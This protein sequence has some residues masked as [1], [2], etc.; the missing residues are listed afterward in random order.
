MNNVKI[1][2]NV[3]SVDHLRE[4][5]VEGE[6]LFNRLVPQPKFDQEDA[7]YFW[8]IENWGTKWDAMPDNIIWEDD[9]TVKFSLETAWAP[10][11]GFYEKMQDLG[12]K[13]DAYYLEE[14]MAFVGRFEDGFDDHYDYGDMSA[15][16]ME[17]DLPEWVED[18]FGL[19]SRTRDD[20][21]QEAEDEEY[22]RELDWERTEWYP[23][24]IKPVRHGMY[25]VKTKSWPFPHKIEFDGDGWNT[26]NKVTEW[27][28][29]TEQ[30]YFKEFIDELNELSQDKEE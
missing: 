14:G 17:D 22:E 4:V 24:K 8:N 20:E 19:I 7:W 25:E 29:I 15:D 6:D 9:N 10:P 1:G 21:D 16:E 3:K 28:G 11:I 30:Q 23:V 18:E 27:R 5:V 26:P 12:Y 13:I 2:S